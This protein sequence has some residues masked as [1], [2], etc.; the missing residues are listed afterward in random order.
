M[1]PHS[2][3]V[4]ISAFIRVFILLLVSIAVILI[5]T[6]PGICYTRF[7]N[8]RRSTDEICPNENFLPMGI[9]RWSNGVH[10]QNRGQNVWGQLAIV[11]IAILFALPPLGLSCFQI[12]IGAQLFYMQICFSAISI[13]VFMT[14]GG[15]ET[16]YATGFSHMGPL[17]RQIGGGQF[18]GCL[19]LPNCY[20]LFVVKGWAAAANLSPNS[21]AVSFV[22]NIKSV[23]IIAD[24]HKHTRH[25]CHLELHMVHQNRIVSIIIRREY[26]LEV[27]QKSIIEYLI[28]FLFDG[29]IPV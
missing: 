12:A 13:L 19:N 20:I 7:I 16:W 11:A 24:T 10:F 8:D 1:V 29:S 5:F 6:A 9:N 3:F 4:G 22:I 23:I 2:L 15:V 17:I 14:L 18:S 27:D 21:I 26:M 28:I 25:R